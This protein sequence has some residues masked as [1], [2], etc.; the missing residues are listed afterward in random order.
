[1]QL[2]ITTLRNLSPPRITEGMDTCDRYGPENW[3]YG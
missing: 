3:G 2:S 1:M